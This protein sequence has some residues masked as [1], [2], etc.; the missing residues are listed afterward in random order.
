MIELA[1]R[2]EGAANAPH[3]LRRGESEIP[4]KL[5]TTSFVN[6]SESGDAT[7]SELDRLLCVTQGRARS[8]SN[9]GLSDGTPLAFAGRRDSTASDTSSPNQKSR[10]VLFVLGMTSQRERRSECHDRSAAVRDRWLLDVT[11]AL[12]R[13]VVI[14]YWMSQPVRSGDSIIGYWLTLR[15]WLGLIPKTVH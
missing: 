3:R 9:R 8:S 10:P 1:E 5:P 12:P 13:C 15:W 7:L 11:T 2:N 4:R 14:G 6:R